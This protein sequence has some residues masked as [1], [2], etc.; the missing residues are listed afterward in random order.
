MRS[1]AK[2]WTEGVTVAD[3]NTDLHKGFLFFGADDDDVDDALVASF[4][5]I[6]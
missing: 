5:R 6:N 3:T 4:A 2:A 1:L